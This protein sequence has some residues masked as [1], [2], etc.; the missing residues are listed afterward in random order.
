MTQEIALRQ[1]YKREGFGLESAFDKESRARAHI[2][3]LKQTHGLKNADMRLVKHSSPMPTGEKITWEVY[4]KEG[5]GLK[6][7][8][9]K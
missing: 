2:S 5:K 3:E 6:V 9:P 4:V 7:V 1:R 8:F